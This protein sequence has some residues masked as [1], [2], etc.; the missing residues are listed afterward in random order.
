MNYEELLQKYNDLLIENTK[1]KILNNIQKDEY[2]DIYKKVKQY[3]NEL[4]EKNTELLN[5]NLELKSEILCLKMEM[6]NP[7]LL[8]I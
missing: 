5:L 1:L 2:I 6:L 4:I 7:P 3:N 8:R